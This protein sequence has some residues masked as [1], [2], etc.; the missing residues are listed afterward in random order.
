MSSFNYD[1]YDRRQN[2]SRNRGALGFYVPLILTVTVATAGL[3]AW[4]WSAREDSRDYSSD[5]DLSYGED[6]AHEKRQGRAPAARDVSGF[7]VGEGGGEGYGYGDGT[8]LGR[9]QGVIRRTPSPQQLFDTVSKKTAAGWAAAGAA[10][11]AALASIREE[12]KDEAFGD[13]SRWNEE[14]TIRRNVEA[15]SRD[16]NAAVDV[17]ARSF[18][19]SV[20]KAEGRGQGY[21]GRRKTVVLVVSAESLDRLDDDEGSYREENATI[22][23]HLP[24]TDFSR[25]K[26]FVLIYS[27]SLRSR[28]QSRANSRTGSSSLGDSYSA[29]STPARTPG[30]ELSSVEPV[31]YTPAPS[32]RGSD[33][34]LWNTLHSQALRLVED[35][36]MV[37]PFN[38]T[39]GFVHML[40]HLGPELVYV[41]DALS[42]VNGQNIDDIRK[43]VGQTI[44]VVGGDGTGLGGLVD[45]DDE[46][47][48]RK[49]KESE[50]TVRWWQVRNDMI[51]LGKGVE[52]VDASR[53]EDDYE[54]RV[55][56]R[57]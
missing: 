16:S 57:E 4:V 18:A 27:P 31:I 43:W 34:S 44:V 48:M 8:L 41:V 10:A 37:M 45:T 28:P 25:T 11:G 12:D 51:G 33:N 21:G 2:N 13:H 39:T 32:T 14:A 40:R 1:R 55:G 42:G 20:R 7:P 29:I 49:G 46:G 50:H 54:R 23:S 47:P 24:D 35:P 30:E 17:Q 56:G 6:S 19:E 15:Q 52:V 26:L 22:L 36:A 3:A 53:L 9:A 5:D 38:T